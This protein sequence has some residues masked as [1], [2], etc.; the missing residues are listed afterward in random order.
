MEYEYHKP[1]WLS[2]GW[3]SGEKFVFCG[4]RGILEHVNGERKLL[5]LDLDDTLLRSDK[6]VSP[7]NLAA[8][9][10]WLEAG[11]AVVVATGRPPRT[12]PS[13]LP[14]LLFSA[15][16]IVYNGAQLWVDGRVVYRNPI[17]ADDVGCLLDWCAASGQRWFIGLEVED[18][19]YVNRPLAKP[20]P[21]EVVDLHGLVGQPVYKMLFFFPEGRGEVEPLLAAVPPT[22]RVLITPK[23]DLIQL[24][25]AG[26]DKATALGHLLAEWDW[27][28]AAVA[29]IGD[30][31]NDL[32]MV[33]CSGIGIAV[34]NALPE[35]KAVAD[36][37][38]PHHDEDG[39]A[40]AIRRLLT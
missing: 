24:C 11:H 19:L 30:D 23:L 12:V 27:P 3:G 15:P 37:V 33:R 6:R 40:C 36:W 20:G 9:A 8:L 14:E 38:V 22:T 18:R 21:L 4:V 16:R 10:D 5:A 13:V 32:E 7:A 28:L 1:R 25:A 26:A 17:P 2:K 31:I 34:E 35:V 29:A 39:V